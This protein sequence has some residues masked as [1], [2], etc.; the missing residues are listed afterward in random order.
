MAG[1]TD[2][3]MANTVAN[4]EANALWNGAAGDQWADNQAGFD[5]MVRRLTGRLLDAA[6]VA[7]G[8]VVVDLG[9]G[10]GDTSRLAAARGGRVLGVDLSARLVA[11]ARELAGGT[12]DL[13][14]VTGDAQT[15]P[16]PRGGVDVMLSRFGAVDFVDP[17]AAYRN[18]RDALRPGG[19]LALL[20]WHDAAAN[21]ILTVPFGILATEVPELAGRLPAEIGPFTR[22]DPAAL[23]SLLTD[24]GLTDAR[25]EEVREPLWLGDTA[26]DAVAWLTTSGPARQLLA[27]VDADVRTR[28]WAAVREALDDRRA[29]DGIWLG[30][31]TWLITARH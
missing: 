18:F 14:F 22:R 13:E 15:Y 28:A 9:C 16:F 25:V 4:T 6:A 2:S 20:A 11:R 30:S 3:T 12:P 5:A 21:E 24:A 23:R 17:A 10:A 7:P 26:D 1:M 31:A 19:R 27:T 29:T 8:D